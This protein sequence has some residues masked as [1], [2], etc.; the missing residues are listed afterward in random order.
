MPPEIRLDVDPVKVLL[1]KYGAEGIDP[2]LRSRVLVEEHDLGI[3]YPAQAAAHGIAQLA[4]ELL[5]AD[6]QSDGPGELLQAF[7][8]LIARLRFAPGAF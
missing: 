3:I 7:E 2:L 5:L 4:V 6:R 8:Q 1:G